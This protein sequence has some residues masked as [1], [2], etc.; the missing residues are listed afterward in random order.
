MK[1]LLPV[2][3]LLGLAAAVLLVVYLPRFKTEAETDLL[4]DDAVIAQF[5]GQLE[6]A[7]RS[8]SAAW[9]AQI[10]Q[11][12]SDQDPLGLSGGLSDSQSADSEA[13]RQRRI[14]G[15]TYWSSLY[16]QFGHF[17]WLRQYRD[18]AGPHLIYRAFDGE[19]PVYT[20][21]LLGQEENELVLLDWTEHP[22]SLSE[23]ERAAAFQELA[24]QIGPDALRQTVE[25]LVDAVRMAEAGRSDQALQTI[26]S[27]PQEWRSNALV[28]GDELRIMADIG[29]PAFPSAVLNKGGLLPAPAI[30]HLAFSWSLQAGDAE[31]L[32]RATEDLRNQFGPDSLLLLFEG[33]A[34]QWA[35]DCAAAEQRFET[36]MQQYPHNPVLPAYAL[37]CMAE[38]DPAA[39]LERLTAIL[40]GTGFTLDE[41]DTWLALEIPALHRSAVYHDWRLQAPQVF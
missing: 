17:D 38:R 31:G 19:K 8:D 22:G 20:D 2:L 9:L 35:G 1:K 15:W 30:A 13:R 10:T 37:S 29:D 23:Q 40:P 27:L 4:D 39:A 18:E 33:L 21:L 14:Q 11:G 6:Q 26:Y 41:L 12:P 5:A 36:V 16:R 24:E 25:V 7:V 34:A 3:G 32:L 28:V